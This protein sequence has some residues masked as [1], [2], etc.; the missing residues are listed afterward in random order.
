MRDLYDLII[1]P[2]F[3]NTRPTGA[4]VAGEHNIRLKSGSYLPDCFSFMISSRVRVQLAPGELMNCKYSPSCCIA[5]EP[6]V[7]APRVDIN[8]WLK[9]LK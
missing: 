6:E 8:Y 1:R 9:I 7:G 2:L 3:R 4:E 5:S